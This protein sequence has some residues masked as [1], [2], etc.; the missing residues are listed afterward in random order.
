MIKWIPWLGVLLAGWL[1]SAP[2]I[3]AQTP[4]N[5]TLFPPDTTSFPQIQ[6]FLDIHNADGSFA[7]GLQ[8]G[9]LRLLEDERQVQIEEFSELR[10]GVQAVLA[11]NPGDSFTP[12]N[13]RGISRYDT[14]R[15]VLEGWLLSRRGS[16]VDDLSL[17]VASGPERT[18]TNRPEEVLADLQSFQL[19]QPVDNPDLDILSQALDVA[20]DETPRLGME[21]AILFITS[22]LAGDPAFGLQDLIERALTQR[23]RIYIWYIPSGYTSESL[24]ADQLEDLA[25]QTG[26]SFFTFSAEE[27]IPTPEVYLS[28][29]RD[30]YRLIYSTQIASSG[31]HRLAVEIQN[32]DQLITTPVLEYSFDLQPPDPAFISPVAQITRQAVEGGS[33]SLLQ[34][35]DAASLLPAEH[36]LQ[37]LVDFPDG[38]TRPLV[39]TRLY[40]DGKLVAENTRPPFDQFTWDLREYGSSGRHLLQ[41]EAVDS[42]GLIG[43][44]IETPVDV[45]VELPG[46]NPLASVVQNAPALLGVIVV[47]SGA[48]VFL[49]LIVTGKIRPHALTRPAGFRRGRRQN[50]KQAVQQDV[51][52]QQAILRVEADGRRFSGWVSRLHWPQRRLAPQAL[53]YLVPLPGSEE[54]SSGS[55]ISIDANEVTLGSD[56]NLAVLAFDDPSVDGL[57][58]RLTLGEDGSFLL[59]DQGSIAGTWIN[60]TPVDRSG[61]RLQH[62]DAIHIGRVGFQFKVRDPALNRKPVITPERF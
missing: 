22:P 44:S 53:A 45:I 24:Q 50:G 59:A 3:Y 7:H 49:V 16:T 19:E 52:A 62:G 46:A 29:L 21:R 8:P 57:H 40:V 14:L 26:G 18:H 58:A 36:P 30:I 41:L 32:G 42:L 1:V 6:V 20:S 13:S 55:P 54:T 51:P 17:M 38:R 60:Y 35:T 11:I 12:R 48:I 39:V 61:T 9:D 43:K 23:V 56:R 15:Q 2:A 25:T 37:V 5:A 34:Q 47:L 33:Q 28:G 31:T 27:T 10:P 4:N